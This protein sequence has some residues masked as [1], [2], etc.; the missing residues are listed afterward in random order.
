MSDVRRGGGHAKPLFGDAANRLPGGDVPRGAAS[1]G[2]PRWLRTI[3][4]SVAFY[5]LLFMLGL[6]C[7]GWQPCAALLGALLS[8]DAGRRIGR[9]AIGWFWRAYLR[10]LSA[11]GLCRFDLSDLDTLRGQPP[12]ILAPNHPG[13]L[14]ALLIASRVP[15]LCCVM[16]ADLAG[17]VF[18]G[19][20]ARLA[21][22]IVNDAPR[23]MIRSAREDLRRGHPLLLFPEGTRTVEG[24]VGS[25][26]GGIALIAARARVP[27]QTLIIETDSPFL[28]KGWPVWRKPAFPVTWRVRRGRRFAP[29]GA[30][31][32]DTRA[33]VAGLQRHYASELARGGHDDAGRGPRAA[34]GSEPPMRSRDAR[35]GAGKP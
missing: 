35:T 14:D 29:P 11:S 4:E 17:N 5:S 27:V 34:A 12:M 10:V 30:A 25:L 3:R 13:L 19:A 7:L 31:P 32:D 23:A 6:A 28:G 16:K 15:D 9:A 21:D 26:K 24:P 22:Y 20:G 33:F 2:L 18:L 1:R 8:P